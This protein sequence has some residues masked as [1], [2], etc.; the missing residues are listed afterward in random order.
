VTRAEG[1]AI[2]SRIDQSP[3]HLRTYAAAD[4]VDQVAR[5]LPTTAAPLALTPAPAQ[6]PQLVKPVEKPHR[7]WRKKAQRERKRRRLGEE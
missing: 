5:A 2:R 3:L 1:K 7:P 6:L 4:S